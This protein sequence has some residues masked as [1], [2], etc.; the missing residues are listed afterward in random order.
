MIPN[1]AV[2]SGSRIGRRCLSLWPESVHLSRVDGR[3]FAADANPVNILCSVKDTVTDLTCE[4]VT[5][6]E[7][8]PYYEQFSATTSL[9]S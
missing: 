2:V 5:R 9:Y 1:D 4:S 3:I 6:S 8:L 7:W